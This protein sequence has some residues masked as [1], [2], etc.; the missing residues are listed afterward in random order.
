MDAPTIY[1]VPL[2]MQE[3]ELDEIVLKRLGLSRKSQPDL[4]SWNSFLYN[5]KNPT[6]EITIGLVGK[7]VELK[8]SY[9]S[10][11]EAFIHGGTA[12]LCRV[13]IEWSRSEKITKANA[14]EILGRLDGILVAPGF[15]SRGITGKINAVQYARENNVPFLGIT[16]VMQ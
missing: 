2:M 10:I 6:S 11:N 14:K 7:Y 13:H 8:D 15:G 1:D 3:E 9:K 5:L 12:N 4:T 16:F